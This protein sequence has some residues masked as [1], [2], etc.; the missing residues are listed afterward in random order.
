MAIDEAFYLRRIAEAFDELKSTRWR[1]RFRI[2]TKAQMNRA[3]ELQ[4]FIM[5][6]EYE[7]RMLRRDLAEKAQPPPD[8][9]PLRALMENSARWT[10][11]LARR[12]PPPAEAAAA[13]SR[14]G[15]LPALPAGAEWP[16]AHELPL[17]FL[18]Q[19]DLSDLPLAATEAAL[20]ATGSLF[21]FAAA[22]E[23]VEIGSD[24]TWPA[25]VIHCD[26]LPRALEPCQPP[27]DLPQIHHSHY[28]RNA[29]LAVLAEHPLTAGCRAVFPAWPL[30]LRRLRCFDA[31]VDARLYG[32]DAAHR[33]YR[34]LLIEAEQVAFAEAFGPAPTSWSF[35]IPGT[36]GHPMPKQAED[37]VWFPGEDW[38][39]TR[40]HALALAWAWRRHFDDALR[41]DE[42]TRATDG[43]VLDALRHAIAACEAVLREGESHDPFTLLT[44]DERRAAR[45]RVSAAPFET[46]PLR[47]RLR[48]T[49]SSLLHRSFF[50]ATDAVLGYAPSLAAAL[51]PPVLEMARGRHAPAT[52]LPHEHRYRRHQLIGPAFKVQGTPD[53]MRRTH[54]LLAQFDSDEGICW[55]WGDMGV[56]QFWQPHEDAGTN[57][58]DRCIA[59]LDG[60]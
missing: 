28:G 44:A 5:Y 26:Q 39:Q 36:A 22:H 33:R 11:G 30:L 17:H 16:R 45:A 20:P 10:I 37:G 35:T 32:G 60:Y 51:S 41:Y 54:R 13:A 55:Q 2:A 43:K 25:R 52:V 14:I 59:T 53:V 50:E 42:R 27:P 24:S 47:E 7:L 21:F 31:D 3:L 40:L 4:E 38:P 6:C 29:A 48:S 19:I 15:G 58:F 46:E 18:A 57:R 34:E 8:E 49:A 9:A 1:R 23:D 56:L 12:F